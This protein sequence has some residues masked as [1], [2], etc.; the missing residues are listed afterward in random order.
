MLR[1]GVTIRQVFVSGTSDGKL[2][3]HNLPFRE[4]SLFLS[5]SR[6]FVA[7]VRTMYGC[8]DLSGRQPTTTQKETSLNIGD[9][10]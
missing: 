2:A 9:L 7:G 3:S 5:V 10:R 4:A 6:K 8:L 1:A